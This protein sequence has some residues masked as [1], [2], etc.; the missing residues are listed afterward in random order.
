MM[1]FEFTKR[2]MPHIYESVYHCDNCAVAGQGQTSYP[3]REW[4]GG[5]GEFPVLVLFFHYAK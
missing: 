2:Q 5:N 3:K 4:E 1:G